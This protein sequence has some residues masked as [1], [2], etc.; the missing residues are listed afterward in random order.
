[1]L[2]GMGEL[3]LEVVAERMRADWKL[4]VELGKCRY[5]ICTVGVNSVYLNFCGGAVCF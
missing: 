5:A 4:D 1:V 3:H 2:G